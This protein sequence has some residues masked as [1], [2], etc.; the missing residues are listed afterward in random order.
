MWNSALFLM[1]ANPYAAMEQVADTGPFAWDAPS[2]TISGKK[3][4]ALVLTLRIPEGAYIEVSRAG[5]KVA[6]NGGLALGKPLFP[7]GELYLDPVLPPEMRY[8]HDISVRVPLKKPAEPGLYTVELELR[9]QGCK[10]GLCYA[11]WQDTVQT[12]VYVSG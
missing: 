1:L 12:M 11:G 8:Q 9:F 6:E 3:G 5:V 10:G 2:Q 4:D 7:K